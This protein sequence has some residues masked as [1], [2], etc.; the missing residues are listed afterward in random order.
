MCR[1][2]YH[3]QCANISKK[4]FTNFNNDQKI[5]W[6]CSCCINT[7]PFNH[8]E[9]D[10][11]FLES[12]P[13]NNL[14]A[15]DLNSDKL[16]FNPYELYCDE[17]EMLPNDDYDPHIIT[18]KPHILKIPNI[19]I[20]VNLILLFL[21]TAHSHYAIAIYAAPLKTEIILAIIYTL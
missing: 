12:L 9:D 14:D 1:S 20:L 17:Q 18:I 10:E 4:N 6:M 2:M 8:L 19:I 3:T 5:N 11:I 21:I 16:L 7:F 15:F 13:S